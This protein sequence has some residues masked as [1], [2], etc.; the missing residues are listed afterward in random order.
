MVDD[1]MLLA[2]DDLIRFDLCCCPT[3]NPFFV[4]IVNIKP[5]SLQL[6]SGLEVFFT[7]LINFFI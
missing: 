2:N 1:Y 6:K 4:Q 5:I 7:D 3:W